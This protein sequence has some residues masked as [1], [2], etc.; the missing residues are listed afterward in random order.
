LRPLR[1]DARVVPD[2]MQRDSR[3]DVARRALAEL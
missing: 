2:S 1:L 3:L